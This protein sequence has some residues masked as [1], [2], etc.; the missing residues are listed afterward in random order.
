MSRRGLYQIAMWSAM[1]ICGVA[2][3]LALQ[4]LP[5][6][7]PVAALSLFAGYCL[8][9]RLL[10]IAVPVTVMVASD[11]VIGRYSWQMMALVYAMLALPALCGA[12]LRRYAT[13][14]RLGLLRWSASVMTCSLAASLAFF[15]VT[16]FGA[17]LWF[18]SYPHTLAGLRDCYVAALP[19][20]RY[21]VTGDLCFATVLFGSYACAVASREWAVGSRQWAGDTAAG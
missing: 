12:P 1:V 6:F 4:D 17:W 3:R 5:N 21:T 20:F 2:L 18:D 13:T 9:N 19:F 16:N 15:V 11:L 10:A 7:A 8:G 14:R